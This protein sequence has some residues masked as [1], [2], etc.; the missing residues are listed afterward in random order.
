MPVMDGFTATKSIR[1]SDGLNYST[2]IIAMT[3]NGL[4]SIKEECFESGMNNI[5]LKPIRR[6]SFLE[7]VKLALKGD[8]VV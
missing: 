6:D 8:V 3:A 5:I 1:E 4:Q 7:T 2:P